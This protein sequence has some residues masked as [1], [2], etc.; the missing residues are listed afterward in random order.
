LAPADRFS[1]VAFDSAVEVVPCAK[2]HLT[3]ATFSARTQAAQW[4]QRIDARGGTEM[5]PAILSALKLLRDE[6]R[7]RVLVFLTDGQVAGEDVLLKTLSR[8]QGRLPRIYTLGIDQSVN[9]GFLRRLADLG[10]G[11]CEVVENEERLDTMMS[12]LHRLIDTPV[13][14]DLELQ[15]RGLQIAADSLSPSRL[16]DVFAATAAVIYGQFTGDVRQAS[17][18]IRGRDRWG[19][20][21]QCEV[22]AMPTEFTALKSLWGRVR[23]RELE[24]R[25]AAGAE[26][27]QLAAKIVAV[28]LE[29]GVLSRFTA[30]VAVDRSEV[31]NSTGEVRQIVQPVEMPRGW[32]MTQDASRAC[33]ASLAA[34]AAGGFRRRER[35][36]GGPAFFA[37]ALP[38][39]FGAIF[40][41]DDES[42]LENTLKEAR[43]AL[44]QLLAASARRR[45]HWL[46]KLVKRL[47][48]LQALTSAEA[49]R[50][51]IEKA[52]ALLTAGAA[53][54]EA[55]TEFGTQAGET[56]DKLTPASS[57]GGSV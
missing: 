24:D 52:Q 38:N 18:C 46:A 28:S 57:A 36:R 53:K 37:K 40:D 26:D 9:A 44:Q 48:A 8:S 34:P 33:F 19:Q 50:D 23:G 32:E 10:R 17:L 30:Y 3:P 42:Q 25:Y 5:G 20:P 1:V 21:F 55:W 31:A 7:E 12:R 15:P 2:H 4:L 27:E 56:L 54:E 41:G 29:A 45:R 35:S 51:L 47:E 6:E 49:L 11:T 43:D 14:T 39:T 16:P 13:L 22:P